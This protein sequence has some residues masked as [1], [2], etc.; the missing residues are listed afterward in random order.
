MSLTTEWIECIFALELK[1]LIWRSFG[2]AVTGICVLTNM[3]IL[4]YFLLYYIIF[5]NSLLYCFCCIV[6]EEALIFTY[7]SQN[8]NRTLYW[9][10][11]VEFSILVRLY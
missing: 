6:E 7:M 3:I 8:H 5:S 9:A 1:L 10:F 2:F 4:F 11:Y